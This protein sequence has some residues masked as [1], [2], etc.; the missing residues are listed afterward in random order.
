MVL[1]HP[2]PLRMLIYYYLGNDIA[3]DIVC[4]TEHTSE[5]VCAITRSQ[6]K[7]ASNAADL[8]NS[9]FPLRTLMMLQ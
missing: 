5:A 7:A 8:R 2:C 1:A 4:F 6:T 9:H 3:G